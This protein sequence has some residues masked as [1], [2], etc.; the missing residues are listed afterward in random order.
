VPGRVIMHTH[1]ELWIDDCPS[2]DKGVPYEEITYRFVKGKGWVAG[3]WDDVNWFLNTP[4]TKY[5]NNGITMV[6]RA[7]RQ[8]LEE[9]TAAGWLVER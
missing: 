4:I 9:L 6:E 7:I 5:T 3:Y 2:Y 8:R 1:D